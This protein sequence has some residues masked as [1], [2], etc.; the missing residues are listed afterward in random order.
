MILL[1]PLPLLYT[2]HHNKAP[3]Y[4]L[5]FSFSFLRSYDT[6]VGLTKHTTLSALSTVSNPLVHPSQGTKRALCW[7][8]NC[9][10]Q[11]WKWSFQIN[12]FLVSC[13]WPFSLDTILKGSSIAF[14]PP[15]SKLFFLPQRLAWSRS[16]KDKTVSH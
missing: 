4:H 5:C 11:T 8:N 16:L 15:I 7:P 3:Y 12:I 9:T 2:S 10:Y 13:S 6:F 14:P 1:Y